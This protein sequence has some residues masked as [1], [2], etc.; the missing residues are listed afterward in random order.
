MLSVM[1]GIAL[2]RRQIG[3]LDSVWFLMPDDTVMTLSLV[4][5]PSLPL[6]LAD[7]TLLGISLL[8]SLLQKNL[9]RHLTQTAKTTEERTEERNKKDKEW[10]EK[11]FW[12][13]IDTPKTKSIQYLILNDVWVCMF[14][15]ECFCMR[16]KIVSV[17][18]WE[19]SFSSFH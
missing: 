14:M 7:I 19:K 5:S 13:I 9:Y 16:Y 8:V 15:R 10:T 2:I 12:I 1:K 6:S 4:H 11:Q 17:A 18:R 3:H